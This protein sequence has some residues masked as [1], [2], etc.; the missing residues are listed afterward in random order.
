MAK[1]KYEIQSG[2]AFKG[3]YYEAGEVVE[4]GVIPNKSLKWLLEQ[5]ILIKITAEY[6]AKKLQETVEEVDDY[7]TEFEEVLEEE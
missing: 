1:N 2:I 4:T 7:D 5:G 6:Q 3:K